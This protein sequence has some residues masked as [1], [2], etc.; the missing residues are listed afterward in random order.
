MFS[1]VRLVPYLVALPLF[2]QLAPEQK[3]QDFQN[4]AAT[5]AKRYAFVEWKQSAIGY[6]SMDLT[7]WLQRVRDSKSDLEF[8]EI[9][10][11]YAAKNQDGHTVFTLPSDFVAEL[12]F[13]V[14][15]YDGK[16]L[17][18]RI[19]RKRIPG[20]LFPFNVGDEL[21]SI[22][23]VAAAEAA[24]KLRPLRG[25]GNSRSTLRN[26]AALLTYRPQVIIPRA[27][28]TGEKANV[29]IRTQSGELLT[30]AIAWMSS[31]TP[32]VKA[33]PVPVPHTSTEAEVIESRYPRT[34]RQLQ[35]FRVP[36]RYSIGVDEMKPVFALPAGFTQ[37][38]GLGRYDSIFS[39]T[40][41]TTSGRTIGFLRFPDFDY[42]SSS[43]LAKE[44]TYFEANTD[45]LIIDVM[46][47]PGGSGC[48][49][50]RVLSYLN[51]QGFYS[52]GIKVRMTWDILQSM[53]LDLELA[54]YYGATA[55]E[56]A[57][58]EQWVQQGKR[59]FAEE[60][61]FTTALPICGTTREVGPAKDKNGVEVVYRK[62]ILVLTDELT[63]SA[64]E[65]FAAVMQDEKR[66]LLYGMRTD[67][68]GGG[69]TNFPAGVF[70]EAGVNMAWSIL[71]RR[72]VIDSGGEYPAMKYIENI[73]VRPDVVDD[74][75]KAEN[76]ADGGK[77]Y[78]ERVLRAMEGWIQGQQ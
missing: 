45:G 56:I 60:R 15:V 59:A 1:S 78:F 48:T 3:V 26:A 30:L 53:M 76:L 14:D 31:G 57:A 43:E 8:F 17:V 55:D 41:L 64:A 40:I 25:D 36:Q 22:D 61:G 71:E 39:G 46:R 23:G 35:Q 7:P 72:N 77:A 29:V 5:F 20:S 10:A 75:M 70:M 63:A 74:Y 66:A 52:T 18:D 69:V 44:V 32:Y 19:D 51:P 58:L 12:P 47:N 54:D 38:L 68:A 13:D 16:F 11:E 67:G 28:E 42:V 21:V 50:E 27:H 37:R 65:I 9:C 24:A 33:G 34:L 73:G 62:P 2:A 6:D 49:T 4:V